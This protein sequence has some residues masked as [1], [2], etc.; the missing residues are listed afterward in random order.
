M[1]AVAVTIR[2]LRFHPITP[3]ELT[4]R[5]AGADDTMAGCAAA[6]LPHQRAQETSDSEIWLL[7]LTRALS[8]LDQNHSHFADEKAEAERDCMPSWTPV[9]QLVTEAGL[10]PMPPDSAFCALSAPHLGD[11]E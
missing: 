3:R 6:V 5:P 9:W 10:S 2:D 7:T 4:H 11:G 8:G 1:S